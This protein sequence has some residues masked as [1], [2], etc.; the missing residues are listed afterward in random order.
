MPA[1]PLPRSSPY[2]FT[3]DMLRELNPQHPEH[4]STSSARPSRTSQPASDGPPHRPPSMHADGAA[5]PPRRNPPSS[6]DGGS[7]HSS[8]AHSHDSDATSAHSE[9]PRDPHAGWKLDGF[10][11]GAPNRA[12]R[13]AD[14]SDKLLPEKLFFNSGLSVDQM[15]ELKTDLR[16]YQLRG[17]AETGQ[18]LTEKYGA[19]LDHDFAAGSEQNGKLFRAVNKAISF[20]ENPQL[21][22]E[23]ISGKFSAYALGQSFGGSKTK[24]LKLAFSLMWNPKPDAAKRAR[25]QEKYGDALN[26]FD[27]NN[28]KTNNKLIEHLM[29]A[30]FPK[31]PRLGDCDGEPTGQKVDIHAMPRNDIVGALYDSGMTKKDMQN[32]FDSMAMNHLRPKETRT[33]K[34]NYR[35]A[36]YLEG[37]DFADRASNMKLMR[38]LSKEVFKP[39]AR[40]ML[41]D[42]PYE[43]TS[44]AP[45]HAHGGGG[46]APAHTPF[47][48]A[49]HFGAETWGPQPGE[50]HRQTAD[51][52]ERMRR[53]AERRDDR[54]DEDVQADQLRQEQ[55]QQEQR[56]QQLH[57]EELRQQ[58]QQ[59][60]DRLREEQRLRDQQD[61][62]RRAE[63]RRQAG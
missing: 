4:A 28:E 61:E 17:N 37:H 44:D 3:A 59:Q 30:A 19:H 26:G 32:L 23:N 1:I 14:A 8:A 54:R 35:F 63:E 21:N 55:T 33:D 56:Q 27:F 36:P 40:P 50:S 34:L 12:I 58:E 9:A 7:E 41:A 20:H 5:V 48:G 16:E 39:D 31:D 10:D 13:V 47:N 62:D 46:A 60:Q 49:N 18:A 22:V 43:E 6:V 2:A 57:Q 29:I 11:T 52:Q 42:A 15:R 38:A 24:M 25:L 53:E 45:M 51:R